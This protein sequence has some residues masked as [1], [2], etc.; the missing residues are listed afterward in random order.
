MKISPVNATITYF[1][2][3]PSSHSLDIRVNFCMN[4]IYYFKIE[5]SLGQR[6]KFP[7]AVVSRFCFGEGKMLS[8]KLPKLAVS[9]SQG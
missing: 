5:Q 7:V 8:F 3:Y 1:S 6:Q 9:F 2:L 4:W